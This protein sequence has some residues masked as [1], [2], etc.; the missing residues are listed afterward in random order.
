MFSICD[1]DTCY[2]QM[3]TCKIC[4]TKFTPVYSSLQQTC[5]NP[6]CV[7]AFSRKQQ[8]LQHK[9]WKKDIIEKHK[10]TRYYLNQMKSV[11]NKFIRLRDKDKGC[12]SCAKRLDDKYDAGHYLT[13][14]GHP[15]HRFSEINVNSQCVYCNRH[16]SGNLVNYRI[17]LVR[18]YGE[19][20]VN[21]LEDKRN[22]QKVYTK[23]ELKQ[24]IEI[25]N[26]KIKNL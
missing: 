2:F 6:S 23:Q 4:K 19:K 25:Y 9:K 21:E 17:G 8:Q 7:L 5:T 11:F 15:A 3:K 18:R 22:A 13:Y 12:I 10:T 1:I 14:A 24:L 20:V 16:L 26:N